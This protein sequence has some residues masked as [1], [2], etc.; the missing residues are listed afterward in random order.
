MIL[1]S[2]KSYLPNLQI[3]YLRESHSNHIE[4][5]PSY[6]Y[7]AI[8]AFGL[9]A[10]WFAIMLHE[11]KDRNHIALT[12]QHPPRS[13][14][15]EAHIIMREIVITYR[16]MYRLF[17]IRLYVCHVCVCVCIYRY[18]YTHIYIYIYIY[19]YNIIIFFITRYLDWHLYQRF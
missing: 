9:E 3:P 15:W 17:M 2:S 18:I 4:L 16:R 5:T 13:R 12:S 6:I 7:F 19:P 10:L 14:C 1:M 8:A 11:I